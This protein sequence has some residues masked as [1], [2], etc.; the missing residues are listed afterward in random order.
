MWTI[1]KIMPANTGVHASQCQAKNSTFVSVCLVIMVLYVNTVKVF[2]YE[3]LFN[4]IE[5]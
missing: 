5:K 4:R 1:A 2:Y 3:I